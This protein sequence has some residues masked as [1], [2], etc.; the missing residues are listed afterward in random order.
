M[1]SLS[2]SHR[3]TFE[4]VL[5]CGSEDGDADDEIETADHMLDVVPSGVVSGFKPAMTLKQRRRQ[6]L[7]AKCGSVATVEAGGRL[8]RCDSGYGASINEAGDVA[9]G[10]IVK[11]KS[12]SV[13]STNRWLNALS[14]IK[15]IADPWQHHHVRNL[16][17]HHTILLIR[18]ISLFLSF[19]HILPHS[20][21][22]VNLLS[23]YLD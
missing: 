20:I 14:R 13:S 15:K 12:L 6:R 2:T 7:S 16:H 17:S 8:E 22:T 21:L 19:F 9:N 1:S 4:L 11:G 10:V 5:S 18:S 23:W 3:V